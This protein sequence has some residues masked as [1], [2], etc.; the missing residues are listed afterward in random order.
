MVDS[1]TT[2]F[3][4]LTVA[5]SL[6]L[7]LLLHNFPLQAQLSTADH[8]MEPGFWPTQPVSSRSDITG[9]AACA[10]CHAVKSGSQRTTAM[11]NTLMPAGKSEI[12][13]SHT[14][15]NFAVGSFHYEIQTGAK[16]SAYSVTGRDRTIAAPLLW[17][18]GTGRVGQSYLFKREDGHFY[19]ARVTYFDTLHSLDFTPSRALAAPVDVEQAMYRPV[20][21]AEIGRCFSCHSTA[22]VAGD[23][24]DESKLIPGVTCEACHGPGAKHVATAEA[25]NVAGA[26]E[27]ARG[28]IFNAA[29]L[30]PGDSVDFCGACHGTF[31]DVRLSG[32][33]GVS[34]VKSQPYRL[35]ESKCWGKGEARL[36]CTSCHNP[37]ESVRRDAAA[38]DTVCLACHVTQIAHQSTDKSTEQ[39]VEPRGASCSVGTKDCVSCHMPKVNV[40][41]MHYKFTDHRI[42]IAR[43]GDPYPE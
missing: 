43:T 16:G 26:P 17:A 4:T 34:T 33:K 38:Y 9:P 19:E 18:F 24:L 5:T 30:S 41:E 2:F 31:W 6:F 36:T 37:H 35:V 7:A 21:A 40:P 29:Q 39:T 23:R 32:A 25:A 12:L 13:R 27:T 3:R 22:A 28:T 20:D 15:M 14:L 11:A 1:S 42:R 10:R 8:L